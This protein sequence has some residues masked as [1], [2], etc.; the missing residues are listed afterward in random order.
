MTIYAEA[1][2][3]GGVE[4]IIDGLFEPSVVAELYSPTGRLIWPSG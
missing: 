3:F 4:P 1:G 2:Y